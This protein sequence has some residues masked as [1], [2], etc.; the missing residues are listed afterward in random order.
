MAKMG[1]G[2]RWDDNGT[3][4]QRHTG[5]ASRAETS[6]LLRMT[7]LQL[8]LRIGPAQKTRRERTRHR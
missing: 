6:L 5:G 3:L 4:G 7:L 8:I 2:F 1:P